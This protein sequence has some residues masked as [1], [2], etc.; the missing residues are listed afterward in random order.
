MQTIANQC[1]LTDG[2]AV[3]QSRNLLML[4]ENRI[5][6][7]ED[8]CPE[9]KS[10]LFN[11]NETPNKQEYVNLY[12][13]PNDGNFSLEYVLEQDGGL[14]I[15]DVHGKT[16]CSY[17]LYAGKNTIPLYCQNLSNGLYLYTIVITGQTTH[18]GKLVIAH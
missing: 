7:F 3:Y 12:P 17:K 11:S 10:T 4:I 9:L 5:L 1:P 16:L 13:N 2:Y 18:H 8:E 15:K 14:N 6:E